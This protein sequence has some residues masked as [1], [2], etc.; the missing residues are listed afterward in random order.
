MQCK[1]ENLSQG[2]KANKKKTIKQNKQKKI[3]IVNRD[4]NRKYVSV[5]NIYSRGSFLN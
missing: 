4:E 5:S 2:P 1:Y 3:T